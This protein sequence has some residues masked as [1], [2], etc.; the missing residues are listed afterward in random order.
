MKCR[1]CGYD[2]LSARLGGLCKDCEVAER[3]E[4]DARSG[5]LAFTVIGFAVIAIFLSAGWALVKWILS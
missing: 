5:C 1:K 4:R 2:M 3:N